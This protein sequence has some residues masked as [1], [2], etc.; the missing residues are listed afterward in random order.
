M[1]SV[2]DEKH[3]DVYEPIVKSDKGIV[4]IY[5]STKSG[6]R[7]EKT[8][9]KFNESKTINGTQ[10]HITIDK[11]KSYQKIIGFGT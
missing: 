6:K 3:Q 4:Q 11:T 9:A 7:F 2:C 8:Q 1:A 5:T 10:W